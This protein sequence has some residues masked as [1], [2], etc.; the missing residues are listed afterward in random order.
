MRYSS[1]SVGQAVPDIHERTRRRQAQPDLRGFT[2]VELLVVITIIGILIALLLPAVQAAREAARSMQCSNN[3]KQMSLGVLV[4]EESRGI[5]PDGGEQPWAAADRRTDVS[6]V[7]DRQPGEMP[8]TAP[9]QNWSWIYQIAPFMEQQNVWQMASVVQIMKTQIPVVHCPSRFGPRLNT[10]PEYSWVGWRAMTDYAG[11]GG[12][13]ETGAAESDY[14]GVLGNGLDAPITRR[15]DATKGGRG[16]SVRIADIT[17][18]SSCTLLAGEKC[19]NAGMAD[20]Y[21]T[22]DD[23]GWTDGWDW[24]NIRWGRYQPHA[25]WDLSIAV[26]DNREL[27]GAFG[28]AHNGYFNGALCDG[29]VRSISFSVSLE[30]FRRLSS[31]NDGL[32]IDGKEF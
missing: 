24:D 28:S 19:L 9:N 29:S 6:N 22:D 25:D 18:G 31:R 20:Q 23:S 8:T 14:W 16:N 32:P 15:P 27:H 10:I 12:L 13:D 3:L 17:D 4:H 7:A 11:N 5:F 30:A 21:Q 2:L 26:K 1:Q